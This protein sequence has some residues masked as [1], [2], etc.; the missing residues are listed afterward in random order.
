[1]QAPVSS[2]LSVWPE[3]PVCGLPAGLS[4]S[5]A[6]SPEPAPVHIELMNGDRAVRASGPDAPSPLGKC[7]SRQVTLGACVQSP[8]GVAWLFL[9]LAFEPSVPRDHSVGW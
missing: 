3:F 8:S 6:P 7:L 5:A 9:S 2:S 4:E 1:M